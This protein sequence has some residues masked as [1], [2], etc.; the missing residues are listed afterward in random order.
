MHLPVEPE[1]KRAMTDF[2]SAVS[3]VSISTFKLS[4]VET[5]PIVAMVSVLGKAF[6]HFDFQTLG[7]VVGVEVGVDLRTMSRLWAL[8][9]AQ[10]TAQV[11]ACF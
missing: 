3:I 11:F 6:S 5:P 10:K 8:T 4:E 2:L 1:S 9:V 7:E